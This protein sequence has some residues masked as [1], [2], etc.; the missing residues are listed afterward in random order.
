MAF[1]DWRPFIYGGGA[2]VFAEFFTFPIDTSKTRLQ[3]QGQHIDTKLTKLKYRGMLHAMYRISKEEGFRALY[4]GVSPALLRQATYGT[5]K[6]G[7]YYSL[8][9][10]LIKNPE[11]NTLLTSVICGIVAG[12]VSSSFANPTDVLKVRMQASNKDFVQQNMFRSFAN[13]Y[14]Q[15]G[16]KG[17]WRGVG[18]TAQRAAVVAGVELSLYDMCKKHII[19][20]DLLGDNVYTHLISS[21]IAG[22]GG[23]ITSNPIDVIKTRMMSQRNLRLLPVEGV[24]SSAIYTGSLDC[25]IQTV[26]TEG[27][28]ALYKG[29]IP[30][31]MRLGPWNVIF[32]LTY[33]QLKL[34]Y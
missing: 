34:L 4:S 27:V 16:V 29:F 25:A 6:I 20:R 10:M 7:I 28:M 1:T 26:R 22:L 12:V 5:I 15:E 17:L 18:P 23:A 9:E 8:K 21:F 11:D 32:F 31:W 14:K 30:S 33:E 13:I 3:I 2:S 19:H 24:Q